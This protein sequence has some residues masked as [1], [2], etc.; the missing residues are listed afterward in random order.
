M[1]CGARIIA[2]DHGGLDAAQE[3]VG[4]D[5]DSAQVVETAL[6]IRSTV[7][8]DAYFAEKVMSGTATPER[9]FTPEPLAKDVVGDVIAGSIFELSCVTCSA[10]ADCEQDC[11][12]EI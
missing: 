1:G 6:D 12:P 2:D 3:A 5:S 10:E 9:M 8:S 11:H 4:P 7:L